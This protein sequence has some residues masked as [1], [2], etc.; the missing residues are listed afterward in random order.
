MEWT[1]RPTLRAFPVSIIFLV[2]MS[3]MLCSTNNG[4][5]QIHIFMYAILPAI[6]L[7]FVAIRGRKYTL[8]NDAITAKRFLQPVQTM[9]TKS[10][11][12]M[13]VKPVGIRAGHIT[14]HNVHGAKLTMNNVALSHKKMEALLSL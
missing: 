8:K 7:L 9:N 6:L 1:I 5:A 3:Y 13:T 2:F 4:D 12:N 11:V 10:I 14:F